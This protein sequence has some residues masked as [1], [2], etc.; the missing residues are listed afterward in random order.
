MTL[1]AAAALTLVAAPAFAHAATPHKV[2]GLKMSEVTS[3]SIGISWS[4]AG[5]AKRYYIQR[6]TVGG[7]WK[8]VAHTHTARTYASKSLSR[9]YNYQYRVRAYNGRYGS[10]SGSVTDYIR[11]P[12]PVTGLTGNYAN[13]S[14]RLD[15]HSSTGALDYQVTVKVLDLATETSSTLSYPTGALSATFNALTP[16]GSQD[17]EVEYEVTPV[18]AVDVCGSP[19]SGFSPMS[20]VF[21]DVV[22]TS[23][24][25]VSAGD[26]VAIVETV[27]AA[28]FAA[29][30][31]TSTMFMVDDTEVSVDEFNTA[32]VDN[33]NAAVTWSLV[34]YLDVDGGSHFY[35]ASASIATII[36]LNPELPN[37]IGGIC[38][39]LDSF[40]DAS[41]K[42]VYFCDSET[43]DSYWAVADGSTNFYDDSAPLG[44]NT[45]DT[46][47]EA[48]AT[49][50]DVEWYAEKLDVPVTVNG[51]TAYYCLRWAAICAYGDPPID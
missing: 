5:H 31:D 30:T 45:F 46:F 18:S 7:S 25:P 14:L 47:M 34:R 10:Y 16:F 49:G 33:P 15:W 12:A 32:V 20:L 28:E 27:T 41:H 22:G 44:D 38:P 23:T 17:S 36:D 24:M 4:K 51:S 37:A 42:A 6:R 9:S 39:L 3:T 48:L 40:S 43:G 29:Q 13:G 8:T 21:T 19:R 2:T 26:Q 11:R 1:C 50:P 35:L